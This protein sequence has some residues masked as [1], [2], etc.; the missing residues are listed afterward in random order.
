MATKRRRWVDT[1]SLFE[2]LHN[3]DTEGSILFDRN[4]YVKVRSD[5][6]PTLKD[7]SLASIPVYNSGALLARL[8]A[9]S[10]FA[11]S[12][13][14]RR[15]E[16]VLQLGIASNGIRLCPAFITFSRSDA[17]VSQRFYREEDLQNW[18]QFYIFTE[19]AMLQVE[20]AKKI[21]EMEEPLQGL[22]LYHLW[23][24]SDLSIS[25]ESPPER[26]EWKSFRQ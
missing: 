10:Q 13:Q 4:H 21:H 24:N 23:I 9:V 18:S 26:Y 17:R 20:T 15:A 3:I 1:T 6:M 11:N 16:K 2:R 7:V 19:R 5:I 12:P 25:R 8:E 14:P 22:L